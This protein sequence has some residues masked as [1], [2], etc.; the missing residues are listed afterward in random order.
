M[1]FSTVELRTQRLVLRPYRDAD[2]P[3]MADMHARADVARYLP[4]RQPRDDEAARAA[5]VRHLA[6]R[7]D[8]DGDGMTLAGFDAVGGRFV[9]EFVLFLK[10]VEHQAG[11]VGYIVHPDAQGRGYATEGAAAMLQLAFETMGMHRVVGRI[12]ARNAASAA[13]LEKLGMQ[14]EAHFRE[15]QQVQGEWVDEV[16]YSVLASEWSRSSGSA[17]ITWNTTA[18]AAA[19]SAAA[20]R[21]PA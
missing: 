6:P 17:V 8:G 16:V 18:P 1:D 11:E 15:N 9:G 10:S 19:R 5:L 21:P 12:D 14:K 20:V 3:A 4:W 7:L 13:V 2:Y